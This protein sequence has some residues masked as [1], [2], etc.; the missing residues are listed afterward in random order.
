MI[1]TGFIGALLV[2]RSAATL[3]ADRDQLADAG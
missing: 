2:W 3:Q 1:P